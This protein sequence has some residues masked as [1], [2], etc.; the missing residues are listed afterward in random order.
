METANFELTARPE[1]WNKCSVRD[2]ND[3]FLKA[4]VV[5][6]DR[7]SPLI[8]GRNSVDK[9]AS[10]TRVRLSIMVRSHRRPADIR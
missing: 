5:E 7:S 4:F 10:K 2:R 3:K 8:P 6:S 9:I 1:E